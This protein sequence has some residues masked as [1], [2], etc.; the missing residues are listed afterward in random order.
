MCVNKPIKIMFWNAQSV[1][2][3]SKKLQLE[4]VLECEKIDLL[5]IAETFLK[6]HHTFNIQNFVVYRNDRQSQP[7]GGVA[8]AIRNTVQHKLCT[9]I[10]TNII[11]NISIE[12]RNR[13]KQ[14]TDSHHIS[15]LSKGFAVFFEWYPT[16]DITQHSIYDFWRFQCKTHL[17]ELPLQQLNG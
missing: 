14:Y 5:L 7:H 2:N 1:T 15:L 9:P 10:T 16:F 12:N 3:I 17:L 8:I 13:N 4:L 6:P 11:E